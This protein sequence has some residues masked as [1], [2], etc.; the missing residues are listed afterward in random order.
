MDIAC[1]GVLACIVG[2]FIS[3]PVATAALLFVYEG[4][5]GQQAVSSQA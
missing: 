2:A 3:V 5:F 1:A 4:L